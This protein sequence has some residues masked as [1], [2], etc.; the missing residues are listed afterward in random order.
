M[1]GEVKRVDTGLSL[2]LRAFEAA[3]DG[4]AAA[5]FQLHI[6]EPFQRRGRAEIL[7]GRLRE[8]RL[9][10]VAYDCQIQIE[11]FLFQGRHRI[12]FQMKE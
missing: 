11:K 9:Q 3:L 12:P 8:G 10:T 4:S 7:S 6:G 1:V 5:R 2:Q